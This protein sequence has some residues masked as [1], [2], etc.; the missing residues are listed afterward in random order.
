MLEN[1]TY[2]QLGPLKYTYTVQKIALQER[3]SVEVLDTARSNKNFIVDSGESEHKAQIRLL[4]TG[5][6]EINR[7]IGAEKQDSGLRALLA[8]F[9]C[10]PILSI[11]NDYLSTSWKKQDL[12]PLIDVDEKN[13]PIKKAK[14]Y[15]NIVPVTL[16]KIELESVPDIPY[17]VQATLTISRIEISPVSES[18]VLNY[19][20][21]KGKED[22]TEDP[23]KAY[24]LKKWIESL[25]RSSFLPQ[26]T[27]SDFKFAKFN[28]R[29]QDALGIISNSADTRKEGFNLSIG[30]GASTYD[31]YTGLLLS[32]NVTLQHKFAYNKLL[33]NG[34]SFPSHMGTTSRSCSMDLVFN[35]QSNDEAYKAFC[36]FKETSDK[37]IKSKNRYDRVKGWEVRSP[38]LNLLGVP[39]GLG[40]TNGVGLFVPYSISSENGEQPAMINCRI[41]MLENNASFYQENEVTLTAG[42]TDEAD[43]R[44]YYDRILKEEQ[45]FRVKLH[46][47]KQAAIKEVRGESD[48]DNYKGFQLFWPIEKGIVNLKESSNFSILNKDTLRAVFLDRKFDVNGTLRSALFEHPLATGQ[49]I[50]NRKI[51]AWD[52]ISYN[53]SILWQ[54]IAGLDQDDPDTMRVF[55]AIK[56]LVLTS[57]LKVEAD[58]ET[59][60]DLDLISTELSIYLTEGFLGDSSGLNGRSS[61]A[62][63]ISRI[64]SSEFAFEQPFKDALFRVITERNGKPRGLPKVYSTDGV[65]ASFYKLITAYTLEKDSLLT[66]A[67]IRQE[68]SSETKN[69]DGFSLYPD[70]VLPSYTELYG[71]DRWRDFAPTIEDLGIDTYNDLSLNRDQLLAVTADDIVSPAAWFY[72]ARKKSG[73]NGLRSLARVTAEEINKASPSLSISVPF[74][75]E[76]LDDIK[77][78]ISK[79]NKEKG[80]K[81][82][83][84]NKTLFEIIENSFL[85][86]RDTNPSGYR[87]DIKAILSSSDKFEEGYL[88][89]E[90]TIK[91]YLHHNGNYAIPREVN[92]PGLGAEIYRVVSKQTKLQTTPGR[93]LDADS[94]LTT[95]LQKDEKFHRHLDSNTQK[96][97]DSCIDQLP[98]DQYS[99]ER[100][101][102]SVRVFLIDRRGKE[103]VAD[104]S[105]FAIKAI[106]SIDVT[107]DK[108]DAPLAVIKIADPLYTLQSDYFDNYNS[109]IKSSKSSTKKVL[110]TLRD[111]EEGIGLKR[112]KLMQ[113]RAIQIRM[114]YGSMA[115]NLPII[116]TGRITEIVPGDELTII[117]QG[118]K[119]ELINKKVSFFNDEPKNWGARDLAI[120]AITY[121]DPDGFG[122]YYPE[123]DS[124]FILR[125]INNRTV[126]E[127]IQNSIDNGQ[128]IDL[129]KVGTRGI[130]GGVANSIRTS[131]GFRS[132]DKYD[133]GFDTRLK[134]I[135]YPDTSLYNNILGVRS[136]FGIMPSWI[137]DSWIIPLQPA[138]DALQEASRHAWNCVVDV[139][140]YDNQATIFMGHP[141]IPYFYT[142]GT[143]LSRALYNK[144]K[145]TNDKS[146]D[147]NLNTLIA[148]F[149]ESK[150]FFSSADATS[151]RKLFNKIKQLDNSDIYGIAESQGTQVTSQD[152]TE[153]I[154]SLNLTD[155]T[156]LKMFNYLIQR[157]ATA[158][159]SFKSL[160]EFS[161][162]LDRLKKNIANSSLP[163]A[164]L[165]QVKG[166]G[167][168]PQIAVIL[169]SKFFGIEEQE[170][171]RKWPRA[172]KEISEILARTGNYTDLLPPIKAAINGLNGKSYYDSRLLSDIDRNVERVQ[173]GVIRS[174]SAGVGGVSTDT[175]KIT[176]ILTNALN[177]YKDLGDRDLINFIQSSIDVYSST[178]KAGKYSKEEDYIS[179]L[180]ILKE[181]I[182]ATN[183][184]DKYSSETS[185]LA[186][187]GIPVTK[188]LNTL[189]EENLML[190]K[191][192][193]Y[194]FCSYVLENE[195]AIK[196]SQE[197]APNTA[198]KL[199]PNMKVF[200]VHHYADDTHNI[201]KNNLVATT[202]EM[203]NTVVI[204]YPAR[205]TAEATLSTEDQ[206]YTQG[207]INS[208]AN[209]IYWPR[210]D[211]T[212]VIGL[213]FHPGL[214]LSNKKVKV[215]TEINC[216]SQDLAAKLACTH[217]AQG[218]R[219]MY[220]GNILMLGKNIKPHDRIILGDKY[221]NM[222]GPVEVESV[223]HHWNTHQGWV[224][225]IIPNAVCDANAGAGILQTAA[226]EAS[227][228]AVFNTLD[229]VSDALMWATIIGTL[230]AAT[231]LAVGKFGVKKS[232]VGL[233]KKF[234]AEGLGG[235][236]KRVLRNY[237]LRSKKSFAAFKEGGAEFLKGGQ[238]INTLRSIFKA[239]GGPGVSILKNELSIGAAKFSANAFFRSSV[240]PAFVDSS[241][242]VD[243][244][245][246]VISPLIFNGNPMT[247]GLETEDSIWAIS[248]FG[249]YYSAK[250]MRRGAAMLYEE[251]FE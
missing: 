133:K 234:M 113:G 8:L 3:K 66:A 212:G 24:W 151:S 16:D 81:G 141:D 208:G 121:A 209:W 149:F 190:F 6:D 218:I 5:L 170:L 192:F 163:A 187:L 182:L 63:L 240:I 14:K 34:I 107:L 224:T 168:S 150:Y 43:L 55:K 145:E 225:N 102:P 79:D 23:S 111:L 242:D 155:F 53:S 143:A 28:W 105:L 228:Q 166:K 91:L 59:D 30:T 210:Q 33:G 189:V 13:Q 95:P 207:R 203:W 26:L 87:D 44:K 110:G 15:S 71:E 20:G 247:A 231:P 246:V 230:G 17:S 114:G 70:L 202:R 180:K 98:D 135:W 36:K 159:F 9:K 68:Y 51:T 92:V 64:F 127:A 213:Q 100:M 46:F 45:T 42:G 109:V 140:P 237:A 194:F 76:E 86:Y 39:T 78:L 62:K 117:A 40:R 248:A 160:K 236:S 65:Y 239:Y 196:L 57:F 195:D 214:T 77:A 206:L 61:S 115:Y 138:W 229:F 198:N 11:K 31:K 147:D 158:K 223:I 227:F 153:Q 176:P 103:L 137:S 164:L 249:F 112:Y 250:E 106:S 2:L 82:E 157:Y 104:D 172:N 27:E 93:R 148:G 37:I 169:F 89:D 244:L 191:V 58:S 97:M 215:F 41:D 7:G 232:V 129:E 152:V 22:K 243:Q 199:P 181:K 146:I 220:R 67:D 116:F 205:G 131:F 69:I 177:K 99:P 83:K 122:D 124:Q 38:L 241:S 185:V 90:G 85:R 126:S 32:E 173:Q 142:K 80:M 174:V 108:Q 72:I 84:T 1:K 183:S 118:W 19:L 101:F 144:Y 25:L 52:K 74:N 56:D 221:T 60:T 139:V 134:N 136:S 12:D 226:M 128:N 18:E 211:V 119:A 123:F 233:A 167:V 219:K 201:I 235:G 216:H 161:S 75:T 178:E 50:A 54:T 184:D 245:P 21:E 188:S 238:T 200:R 175:Y 47:N 156:S 35:N 73:E 120:Q 186:Q 88:Q 179:T 94:T 48:S 217:L 4:F 222:S 49:V 154:E 10:C 197:M 162:S 204:E 132:T 251:L 130:A 96:L 171:Q 165:D 29:N 125:N 193:V